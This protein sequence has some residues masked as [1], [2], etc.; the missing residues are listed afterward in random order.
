MGTAFGG[1]KSGR[2]VPRLVAK[3]MTGKTRLDK[4]IT[5]RMAFDDINAAFDL[6]KSGGCLR[7]VL[8]FD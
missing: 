3:Y 8:S 2:D 6:M 1:Y 5:H 4:Y 7:V